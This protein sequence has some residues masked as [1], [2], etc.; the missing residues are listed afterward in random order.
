MNTLVGVQTARLPVGTRMSDSPSRR[1]IPCSDDPQSWDV[2]A[3]T[4]SQLIAAAERCGECPFFDACDQEAKS[5]L[6]ASMVW[7]GTIYDELGNEVDIDT[8]RAWRARPRGL[9]YRRSSTEYAR[10]AS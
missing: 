10:A 4:P 5:G 3:A 2:D 8:V 9:I 1:S 6:A 7:A